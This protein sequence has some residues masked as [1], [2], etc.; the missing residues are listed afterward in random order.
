MKKIMRKIKG[1][2]WCAFDSH[3]WKVSEDGMENTCERCGIKFH[4]YA[5]RQR[6]YEEPWFRFLVSLR[7]IKISNETWIRLA[8]FGAG[9]CWGL[10]IMCLMG[11]V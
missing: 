11:V 3:K 2:V 8:Y 1:S 9:V 6:D 5:K 4:Y 7:K 10:T